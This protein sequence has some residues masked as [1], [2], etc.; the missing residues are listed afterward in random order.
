MKVKGHRVKVVNELLVIVKVFKN[1]ESHPLTLIGHMSRTIQFLI[2][3]NGCAY[4]PSLAHFQFCVR[5]YYFLL[6]KGLHAVTV[7]QGLISDVSSDMIM[8]RYFHCSL[9]RA[10]HSLERVA[11]NIT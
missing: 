1:V 7:E 9:C 6:I 8:S 10:G 4:F 11:N 3:K 5:S 2:L